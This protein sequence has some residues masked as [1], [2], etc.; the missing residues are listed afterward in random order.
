[1][2]K[3]SDQAKKGE[4]GRV[5]S[6]HEEEEEKKKNAYGIFVGKQEKN[7]PLGRSRRR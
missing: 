7:K 3:D 6:T 4:M 2:L 1:M 5:R